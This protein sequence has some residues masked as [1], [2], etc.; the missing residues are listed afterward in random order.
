[1]LKEVA[2]ETRGVGSV[3]CILVEPT[4]HC[5]MVLGQFL[6]DGNISYVL[7]HILVVIRSH[8][9]KRLDRGKTNAF[10]VRLIAELACR[11]S[12]TGTRIP[13]DDWTL[14]WLYAWEYVDRGKDIVKGKLCIINHL[15]ISLPGFLE[16]FYKPV[17][18]TSCV[19]LMALASFRDVL[20]GNYPRAKRRVCRRC[21]GIRLTISC[22]RRF[23]ETLQMPKGMEFAFAQRF[24]SEF[25]TP[26]VVTPGNY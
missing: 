3:V 14:I 18:M 12:V 22:V 23:F 24:A 5:W 20:Q 21:A 19:C 13:E 4:G 25:G 8:E 26:N 11:E 2:S 15:E 16:I 1:M 7:V 6:K 17:G 10:N 9:M